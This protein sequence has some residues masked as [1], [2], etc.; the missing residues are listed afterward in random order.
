MTAQNTSTHKKEAHSRRGRTAGVTVVEIAV[1]IGVVTIAL[2]GLMAAMLGAV[3]NSQ[4]SK[5]KT[6]AVNDAKSILE[7]LADL[8]IAGAIGTNGTL[9]DE[10]NDIN[11]GQA[12]VVTVP[13]NL[14]NE[15]ATVTILEVDLA[16]QPTTGAPPAVLGPPYADSLMITVQV[17]FQHGQR[18]AAVQVS[19]VITPLDN[20]LG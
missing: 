7:Q 9:L 6:V 5:T 13:A 20:P 14:I 19:K 12:S 15:Q 18:P 1:A 4:F 8:P 2:T 17:N 3:A 11:T 10:I 16:G